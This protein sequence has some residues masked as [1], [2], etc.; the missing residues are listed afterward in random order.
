MTKS[1]FKLRFDCTA[2]HTAHPVFV[3]EFDRGVRRRSMFFSNRVIEHQGLLEDAIYAVDSGQKIGLEALEF[4]REGWL[5]LQQATSAN[6]IRAKRVKQIKMVPA[7]LKLAGLRGDPKVEQEKPAYEQEGEAPTQG[8]AREVDDEGLVIDSVEV[9]QLRAENLA[10]KKVLLYLKVVCARDLEAMDFGGTSDPYATIAVGDH[11]VRTKTISKSLNPVW[12][13]SFAMTVHDLSVPLKISVWDNDDMSADDVIGSCSIWLEDV[14]DDLKQSRSRDLHS[15]ARLKITVIRALDL[16]AADQGGTSDPYVKLSI[17]TNNNK[18]QMTTVKSK[19]LNPVWGEAF[20]FEIGESERRDVLRIECFDK[21]A[22]GSDDSLGQIVIELESLSLQ[23]MPTS[24]APRWHDFAKARG[25]K[26]KGQIELQYELIRDTSRPGTREHEQLASQEQMSNLM[27]RY[28][29][30]EKEAYT[31]VSPTTRSVLTAVK[32]VHKFKNHSSRKLKVEDGADDWRE[33]DLNEDGQVDK[34]EFEEYLKKQ[35]VELGASRVRINGVV[36][37]CEGSSQPYTGINGEY[38]RTEEVC[39]QRA[40]YVKAGSPNTAMWWTNSKGTV[41][42]CVGPRAQVGNEVSN[43]DIWAYVP[44]LGFGPEEA[45]KRPWS[46]YSYN[47]RSFDQQTGVEVLNLDPRED[48]LIEE[49]THDTAK[50]SDEAKQLAEVRQMML[51][52]HT[53]T[54]RKFVRWYALDRDKKV[55]GEIQLSFSFLELGEST[56]Y[57]DLRMDRCRHMTPVAVPTPNPSWENDT[58]NMVVDSDCSQLRCTVLHQDLLE[59]TKRMLVVTV[60]RA[61]K[62][63]AMDMALLSGGSSD[64]YVVIK[65]GEETKTTSIISKNLNPVWEETF[66][67]PVW[68]DAQGT[69]L[70]SVWDHDALSADDTIGEVSI[71]ISKSVRKPIR[72]WF[73]ITADGATTGELEL[74]V[75]VMDPFAHDVKLMA[76]IKVV[77][78]RDLEAMDVGGS[79]DPYARVK[80]GDQQKQTAI[81]KKNLSPVW[82]EEFALC[83]DEIYQPLEVSVWDNDLVG[84]D[85]MIGET[86]VFLADLVGKERAQQWYTLKVNGRDHGEVLLSIFVTEL[87]VRSTGEFLGE[88]RVQIQGLGFSGKRQALLTDLDHGVVFRDRVD[89]RLDLI[90]Q[91]L[92]HWLWTGINHSDHVARAATVLHQWHMVVRYTHSYGKRGIEFKMNDG[93]RISSYQRE[94]ILGAPAQG[95]LAFEIRAFSSLGQHGAILLDPYRMPVSEKAV[96]K[97]AALQKYHGNLGELQR[98]LQVAQREMEDALAKES[99]AREDLNSA[100]SVAAELRQAADDAEPH[101]F[102]LVEEA[103]KRGGLDPCDVEYVQ[104]QIDQRRRRTLQHDAELTQ[105]QKHKIWKNADI[106]L[107]AATNRMKHCERDKAYLLGHNPMDVLDAEQGAQEAAVGVLSATVVCAQRL[108]I[109]G[110]TSITN[111]PCWVR[112]T[113]GEEKFETTVKRANPSA[114]WNEACRMQVRKGAH[115]LNAEV[116]CETPVVDKGDHPATFR[117]TVL[118]AR[119]LLAADRGGTSDPYVRIHVGEAVKEFKKTKVIKKTLNPEFDETFDIRISGSQRRALLTLECFDYDMLGADDSLGKSGIALDELVLEREYSH[120]LKLEG[121]D[122]ENNGEIELRYTLLPELPPAKLEISVLRAKDLI[123]ADR[124]GTSDPY[125][126]VNVGKT[127]GMGKKTKVRFKTLNPEWNQSFT[128]MLVGEMRREKLS[129]E[130]FDYD[131]VGDDDSLGK[132]DIQLDSLALDQEYLQWRKLGAD[133]DEKNKGQIQVQYRLVPGTQDTGIT[134]LG[135]CKIP[136]RDFEEGIE[137]LRWWRLGNSGNVR[138]RLLVR[139]EEARDLLLNQ[140]KPSCR[141]WLKLG[142]DSVKTQ[143]CHN[144]AFPKWGGDPFAFDLI[145]TVQTLKLDVLRK[146]DAEGQ[147]GFLGNAQV[148]I[149][150]IL[151]QIQSSGGFDRWLQLQERFDE[152]NQIISGAVRI[153][154]KFDPASSPSWGQMKL[155]LNYE[156]HKRVLPDAQRNPEGNNEVLRLMWLCAR[157]GIL[158]TISFVVFAEER[159]MRM[160]AEAVD[161]GTVD[162]EEQKQIEEAEL[163]VNFFIAQ[164]LHRVEPRYTCPPALI[165]SRIRL[166]CSISLLK[167]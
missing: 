82:N 3:V 105:S 165:C 29:E 90:K 136:L 81:V 36:L 25:V 9:R 112:L 80:L 89:R 151:D 33:L 128:F 78:A 72:R 103:Q 115:H 141:V 65:V 73:D 1:L 7:L 129:I 60:H 119:N 110:S 163:Q 137:S 53:K 55:R 35:S 101:G 32:A 40:V 58:V 91:V 152:K 149:S 98:V 86:R 27:K 156:H 26:N 43:E 121:E 71:P 154:A 155:L 130:C 159:L 19:T 142:K 23:D 67:I 57:V 104:W 75:H 133:G 12:D 69:L 24:P 146:V 123:A 42:W 31:K 37:H 15:P 74:S 79:S 47:T 132:F 96:Q 62:L 4:A 143:I 140:G 111:M 11:K 20:E 125:V 52:L 117:L 100:Q 147:E 102:R 6:A 157:Q 127:A 94:G 56:A 64:P 49:S 83:I 22:F 131:M 44:S 30:L 28:A 92:G 13:E 162:E 70:V 51:Q 45:R 18:G 139:V 164:F 106:V 5:V 166:L 14:M 150:D 114:L 21:D 17:G 66:Q 50:L 107:Q 161:D 41:C 77:A 99:A 116:L 2:A 46:V 109:P 160:I 59:Q 95:R 148:E 122:E 54:A 158:I 153:S 85:D 63:K 113:V 48:E 135:S 8:V 124:A 108:R 118:R 126:R 34:D 76:L 88:C 144:T 87:S 39:N 120:W 38:Q 145:D 97:A 138:G 93:L 84:A 16:I 61:R 134:I 68:G 10:P 167:N